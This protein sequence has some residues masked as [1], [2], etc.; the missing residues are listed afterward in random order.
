[1]KKIDQKFEYQ[2]YLIK[3]KTK[4]NL[5]FEGQNHYIKV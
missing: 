2:N 4:I 5:K 1:M 3:N